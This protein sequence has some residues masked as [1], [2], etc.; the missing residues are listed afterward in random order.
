MEYDREH[1][2]DVA[3]CKRLPVTL[4]FLP[5]ADI[6]TYVAEGNVDIGLTGEDIIAESAAHVRVLCKLGIG[7]CRL[8]VQAPIG[9]VRSAKDL[10]GKRIVTSFPH[11]AASYFAGVDPDTPT[12]IK[13]VFS[14]VSF[15]RAGGCS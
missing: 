7:K 6:A 15:A 11:L 10:A 12:K 3:K 13:S 2:L 1:R 5:A 4:V 14:F 8:S 9:T